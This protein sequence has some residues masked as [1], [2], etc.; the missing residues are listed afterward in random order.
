MEPAVQQPDGS[1]SLPYPRYSD[2]VEEIVQ[3]MYDLHIVVPFDWNA[4]YQ[5]GDRIPG[6]AEVARGSAAEAARL[7]TAIVRAERFSEGTLANAL[8]DGTL[9]AALARLRRWYNDERRAN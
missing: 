6:A 2:T 8:A 5:G 4:W 9:E 7:A 1:Y 3:L